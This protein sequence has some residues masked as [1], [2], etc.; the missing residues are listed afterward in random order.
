MASAAAGFSTRGRF[1]IFIA[2]LV[3]I[4]FELSSDPNLPG[5]RLLHYE[6][7]ARNELHLQHDD[8]IIE[9]GL[10]NCETQF[11]PLGIVERPFRLNHDLVSPRAQN[12][13][14]GRISRR[15]KRLTVN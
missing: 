7:P 6:V 1:P 15:T 8:A 9:E 14:R 10:S 12:G 5:N 11:A 3:Q 2:P 13:H 4:T